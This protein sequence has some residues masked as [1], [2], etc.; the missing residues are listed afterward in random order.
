ML[1]TGFVAPGLFAG[2]YTARKN[3]IAHFEAYLAL[4]VDDNGAPGSLHALARHRKI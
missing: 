4:N 2:L 1:L 3:I